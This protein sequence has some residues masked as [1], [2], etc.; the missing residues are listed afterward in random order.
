MTNIVDSLGIIQGSSQTL[1]QVHQNNGFINGSYPSNNYLA[2]VGYSN[3]IGPSSGALTSTALTTG[4]LFYYPFFCFTT[5][6]FKAISVRVVTGV[7]AS[8]INMGVYNSLNGQ[9]TGSPITGTMS[10][11]TASTAS[12]T[13]LTFTFANPI[14]LT[15]GNLYYV[16][17]T[18]SSS[19]IATLAVSYNAT[20]S[21][22][23]LGVSTIAAT[24]TQNIGWSQAFVYNTTLPTAASLTALTTLSTFRIIYLQVN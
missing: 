10:G 22:T 16:A 2:A 11:S 24:S 12:N 9:P 5:T 23:G 17:L 18:G 7:A 13:T 8:N 15:A 6:T 1:S 3:Q 4:T 21:F 19:T 14:V 20:G